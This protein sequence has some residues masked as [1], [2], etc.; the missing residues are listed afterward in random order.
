MSRIFLVA[1]VACSAVLASGQTRPQD[2]AR[3][4]EQELARIEREL[5]EAV[6][7]RD[8][9]FLDRY[10]ADDFIGIDHLGQEVTKAQ[11]LARLNTPGYELESLR[12]ENIRVRVFGDC[13]VATARS[14]V[15]GRY[16]GQEAGGVFPYLRVWIKR[17]GR[18]QA[19]SAQSS[20]I[21]QP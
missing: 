6:L 1:L 14:V 9:A 3:K 2:N 18:W 5:A 13:G 16:K 21:P 20:I 8:A 11:V 10:T 7:R 17:Q 19:V 12:H 4:A 15:K